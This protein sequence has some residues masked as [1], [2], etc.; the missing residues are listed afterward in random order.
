MWP[1]SKV[2][3][4]RLSSEQEAE[5]WPGR[6]TLGNCFALP[7]LL[8]C[9]SLLGSGCGTNGTPSPS[10]SQSSPFSGQGEGALINQQPTMKYPTATTPTQAGLDT[11]YSQTICPSSLS[12][13]Q[14]ATN[15]AS[16]NTTEFGNFD[17]A[18]NPIANN[19]LGIKTVDAI[20]IDYTA[21]NI[22]QSAVTV[23]G[24][25]AVPEVAPASL[26]G[27]ILYFH[28]TTTQRTNVPSNFTAPANSSYT[29]GI[30]LAAVWASQGYVVVMPDYIGL[31]DDTTHP[32]PYVVYP[33]Q[34]AQSGLAMVKAARSLLA[35]S[36]QITGTLPLYITGY[37]EGGAYALE[38]AHLMQDNSGYASELNVQLRMAAPLSGFFDLSG[39]GL[40]YLF[41]NMDINQNNNQWYSPNPALSIASK[42]FLSAYLVLSFAN[43]SG[44]VPTDILTSTFYNYP[45]ASGQKNC[46]NLDG[47]Y[48]TDPQSANYDLTVTT[49]ALSQ[50]E[51][52][53]NWGF[54]TDNSIAGLL[55]TT[56]S[57]ALM[58]KDVNNPLYQQVVNAD[59]YE[60]V[61]SFPV[62][63]ISLEQDSV[64]TR[65]NSDVAFAYFTQH[66][67]QGLYQEELVPNS[68]FLVY[69]IYA[70]G[71]I[72]HTTE[73]PFLSILIL[74]QFNTARQA[75]VRPAGG[76]TAL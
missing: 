41:D 44:I 36:Y 56:Y 13:Q 67:S 39:T 70:A 47:L 72:D 60:F 69:G 64:V 17:L 52:T 57:T 43:Y 26:K 15:E 32:H 12:T 1:N 37:S 48:F 6:L 54:F 28:G 76:A 24:G 30:L 16:L 2:D 53:G 73:F 27:I 3:N 19:S 9:L 45:C 4:K 74:N 35:G 34:N 25:I 66:N 5:A 68:D 14:C 18:A 31:G 62:T 21:V 40:S 23:S 8:I 63:L 50:A 10:L 33:S 59:T 75:N 22:D 58:N 42:P 71:P 7:F 65:K 38:A 20:K 61:P 29:D 51:Y 11:F 55:T 46:D 49:L